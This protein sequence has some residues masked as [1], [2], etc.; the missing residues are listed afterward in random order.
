MGHLF[1]TRGDL[2]RLSCDAIL[3]P[4]DDDLNVTAGWQQLLGPITRPSDVAGWLR[5]EG[6]SLEHGLARVQGT[7]GVQIC[8]VSTAAVRGPLDL[9]EICSRVRSAVLLA[10]DGCAPIHRALPLVALPIVG[11]G[12]GGWHGRELSVVRA[13]VTELLAV[14]ASNPVDVALVLRDHADYAAVQAVRGEMPSHVVWPELDETHLSVARRLGTLA[15]SQGLS[16]FV[17]AGASVPLGL[18]NWSELLRSL[19]ADA[20]LQL[21]AH[22]DNYTRAADAKARLGHHAFYARL[23][24]EFSKTKHAIGHALLAGLHVKQMVTTNYDPCLELALDGIH[25][26]GDYR[27]LTMERAHGGKAWLLKLHGDARDPQS[28]VLTLDDYTD[29]EQEAGALL[30]VVET[31]LLTSHLLFVGF[32]LDDQDFNG[33]ASGVKKVLAR[34]RAHRNAGPVAT[35]LTL[36]PSS[37]A[38]PWEGFIERVPVGHDGDVTGAARL[39]EVLLDRLAWESLQNGE[40]AASFLLDPHYA[41]GSSLADAELRELLRPLL[42]SSEVAKSSAWPKIS[43]LLQSLGAN[44]I[45]A[46]SD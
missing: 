11:V 23:Q 8:L 16:L 5:V 34:G 21:L 37:E 19:E 46:R 44:D 29:L 17:G 25:E 27:V 12:A 38:D 10:C 30:G 31:L 42:S 7:E 28:I 43:R 22:V 41:D 20:G 9:H 6:V 26:R 39:L 2:A 1:V 33:L 24:S 14:V 13:M 3:I 36:G 32:G 15:A 18:P 45:A 40:L 35:S 4:C